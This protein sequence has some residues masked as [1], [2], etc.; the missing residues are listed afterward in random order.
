MDSRTFA[1]RVLAAQSATDLWH[2][3]PC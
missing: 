1:G 3:A 2:L